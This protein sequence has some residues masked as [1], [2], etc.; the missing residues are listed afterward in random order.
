MTRHNRL[1]PT[2]TCYRPI[3]DLPHGS[4]QIVT[5]LLWENWCN[6]FCPIQ[7]WGNRYWKQNDVK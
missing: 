4:R 2:Q 3:A 1:L 6:G 7:S 5:E